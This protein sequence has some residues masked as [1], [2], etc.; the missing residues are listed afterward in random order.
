MRR[1]AIIICFLIFCHSGFAQG[2]E[3]MMRS[4]KIGFITNR[5]NLTPQQAEKFWPVYNQ[6][7]EKRENLRIDK[8]KLSLDMNKNGLTDDDAKKM[9]DAELKSRRDDLSL[10]EEFISEI[11]KVISS[12]QA[13]QLMRAER[14]FNMEVL[15]N[16]RHRDDNPRQ[17]RRP[18]RNKK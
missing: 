12:S 1:V 6:F 18:P 5:L 11:Q 3:K 4:A 15:R 16:L 13:L 8:R 2:P 17:P 14:D 7:E 10:N 9:I